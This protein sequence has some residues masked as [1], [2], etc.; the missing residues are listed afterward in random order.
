MFER[1]RAASRR[2]LKF[3]RE[4]KYFV[5]LALGI[6]FAAINT[7]NN[8]LFLILG[9]MLALIV[10][11]GVLSEL[12]LRSLV[13]SRHSPER[14]FAGKPFLMGI[15][16]ANQKRRL[17]SFSIEV[18]DLLAGRSLDKKCYFLKVPAGRTQHTSYRHTFARRGLY[19]FSGYQ[20]STKFPFALFRKS[21][22]VDDGFEIVVYPTVFPIFPPA[23]QQADL[24]ELAIARIDRRGDFHAMREYQPGDDP[25]AIHWRKSAQLSR[26]VIR[27]NEDQAT[28]R[29]AIFLDNRQRCAAPSEAELEQQEQAVSHAASLAVH[30]IK[31]GYT[32]RLVTRSEGVSAGTGPAQLTRILRT[33]A[34]LEFTTADAPYA[35]PAKWAGECVFVSAAAPSASP[36]LQ[37]G[38]GGFTPPGGT[39]VKAVPD[40][41]AA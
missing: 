12:T 21:R 3:T 30:Y 41:R 38:P 34:L 11:S 19:R 17:P 6:G 9:M 16:L 33:L 32:V 2:S 14:I 39:A 37:G 15:G 7:G 26:L 10:G 20:I 24:G 18:E 13:V 40:P 35:A 5:A 27:E 22:P 28:R 4:G 23:G 1:W 8:L 25:R 29:I 36:R 31:R